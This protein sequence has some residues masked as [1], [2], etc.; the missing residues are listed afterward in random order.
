MTPSLENYLENLL[1][2]SE[3]GVVHIRDIARAAEVS[4][5]NAT[6][7]VSRLVEMGLARHEA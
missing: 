1:N 3:K 6:R 7:A 5:P 4:L 2:H